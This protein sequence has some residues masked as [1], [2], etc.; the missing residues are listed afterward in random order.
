[1]GHPQ[2]LPHFL[3][4]RY[5]MFSLRN[6]A[7][8]YIGPTV[9]LNKSSK[10]CECEIQKYSFPLATF[11]RIQIFYFKKLYLFSRDLP[12][13]LLLEDPDF[14]TFLLISPFDYEKRE[15][16]LR[17]NHNPRNNEDTEDT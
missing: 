14:S 13:V 11:Y 9:C 16:V 1:M 4:F 3:E 8:G 7:K 5:V 15:N 12:S 17:S 10:Y 6:G 2:P